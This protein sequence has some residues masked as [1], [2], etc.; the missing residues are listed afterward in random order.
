MEFSVG[1]SF[2]DVTK[3]RLVMLDGGAVRTCQ[4]NGQSSGSV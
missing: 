3:Y 1:T 4:S 2:E